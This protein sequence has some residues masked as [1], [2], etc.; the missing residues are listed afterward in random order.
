M[1]QRLND[2]HQVVRRAVGCHTDRDSRRLVDQQVGKGRREHG[3]LD[4][5]A[6]VIRFEVNGVLVQT[7]GHGH[8]GCCHSAL[9][10][11]HGG[12]TVVKRSKVA[13]AIDQGSRMVHGC[14]VLTSAS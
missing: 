13:V 2:L 11:T 12:R 9:C 7:I 10:V 4:V 1:A 5:L 14:A 3:R 8:C 6:V